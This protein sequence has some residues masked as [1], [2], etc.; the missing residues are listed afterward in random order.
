MVPAR[1]EALGTVSLIVFFI[2]TAMRHRRVREGSHTMLRHPNENYLSRLS[3]YSLLRVRICQ[4]KRRSRS[5]I[6][7]A[8]NN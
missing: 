8:C 6:R 2:L 1:W 5:T 7:S 4:Q 3:G